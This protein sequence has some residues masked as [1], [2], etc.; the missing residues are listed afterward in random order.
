MIDN[1]F[2]LI[3]GK[4]MEKKA[5]ATD[6]LGWLLLGVFALILIVSIIMI[7]T[8]K[9]EAAIEYIKDTLKWG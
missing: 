5:I 3:R 2:Y 7:L 6:F 1:L 9:G 4:K 8:G